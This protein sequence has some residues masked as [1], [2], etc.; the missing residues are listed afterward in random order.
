MGWRVEPIFRS[1]RPV[2]VLACFFV[3]LPVAAA[4]GFHH[5]GMGSANFY[6][7]PD[8]WLERILERILKDL[9]DF[10]KAR[11]IFRRF[12]KAQRIVESSRFQ[13]GSKERLERI[14][15]ES[16]GSEGLE[17]DSRIKQILK[18]LERIVIE[19]DGSKRLEG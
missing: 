16:D 8:A 17:K 13:K 5:H 3:F 1:L 19:S 2:V 4:M 9:K 6:A 7:L 18:R 10:Q 12:E 14:I 15:I 11:S